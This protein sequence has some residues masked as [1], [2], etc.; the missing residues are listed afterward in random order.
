VADAAEVQGRLG[1]ALHERGLTAP[2]TGETKTQAV[3]TA[4]AR[5]ALR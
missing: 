5:D 4:L 1:A 3:L 2:L